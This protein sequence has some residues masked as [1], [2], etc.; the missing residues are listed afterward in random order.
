MTWYACLDLIKRPNLWCK[1]NQGRPVY[2]WVL[3]KQGNW[4]HL[5][6][7]RP[8]HLALPLALP[9]ALWA[10]HPVEDCLVRRGRAWTWRLW[11][12]RHFSCAPAFPWKGPTD[13]QLLACL[14]VPGGVA[15]GRPS[16]WL[17]LG[18]LEDP[19]LEMSIQQK[20]LCGGGGSIPGLLVRRG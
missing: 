2:F 12:Q 3:V 1:L 15:T 4:E 6:F 17:P 16:V 18:A 14:S 13:C 9:L 5:A 10:S 19:L 8:S 7:K 11:S 20:G